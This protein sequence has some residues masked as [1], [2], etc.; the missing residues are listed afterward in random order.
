MRA[1]LADMWTDVEAAELLCAEAGRLRESGD[2]ASIMA[3]AAAKYFGARVAVRAA[4]DA[5][6]IHGANGCSDRYPVQR[7]F[8]D[9]KVFEIIE[10]SSQIQQLLISHHALASQPEAP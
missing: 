5:V 10:G 1:M 2:P 7:Y 4:G 9:A 8:R 6:Q 3:T